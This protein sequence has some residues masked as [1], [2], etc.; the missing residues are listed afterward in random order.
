MCSH[1]VNSSVNDV[2]TTNSAFFSVVVCFRLFCLFFVVVCLCVCLFF[3]S[4]IGKA[5][6]E[7]GLL[8][9]KYG[10]TLQIT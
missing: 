5:I 10:T 8:G 7:L 9:I 4:A 2:Y 6:T 3:H 1:I